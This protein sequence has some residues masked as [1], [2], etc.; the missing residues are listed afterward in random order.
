MKK[1]NCIIVD[2]EPVARKILHEFVEQV[3]FLNMQGK[4][5]NA[6]KAE[7]F[8]RNN[9]VDLIF[10]D[11]EMPKTSGLQFLQKMEFE[12]T[13]AILTTAFPQYALEGY[14]LD[15]IDYLLKPFAFNRFL[16]A[17]HKARDF[18]QMRAGSSTPQSY[19]FIKSEKRI[20]KL[21]LADI[22]YAESTGNYV[23]I[24]TENQ[25]VI[26]YLTM[27]SLECQLPEKMFIKIHQSYLVNCDRIQAIE[28]NEIKIGNR[29]LPMSRNYR[30]NVMNIVQQRLLKR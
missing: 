1:L 8:L 5:E 4:F 14:E 15:I 22:M 3:P 30:D 10:L 13:M 29:S 27:K 28:G 26:A 7:L 25:K 17:V 16:K 19:I 18:Y 6:A 23:S 20:E 24:F 21:E 2:D 11:I 12:S 9:N